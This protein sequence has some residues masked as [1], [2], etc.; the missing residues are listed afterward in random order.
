M[1]NKTVLVSAYIVM[2]IGGTLHAGIIED[3]LFSSFTSDIQKC[4]EK[5][6]APSPPSSG[7]NDKDEGWGSICSALEFEAK[8][9]TVQCPDSLADIEGYT[10]LNSYTKKKKKKFTFLS[11]LCERLFEKDE[12]GNAKTEAEIVKEKESSI[13]ASAE[14][15]T[16]DNN[17]NNPK[18]SNGMTKDEFYKGNNRALNVKK[19]RDEHKN[20]LAGLYLNSSNPDNQDGLRYLMDL[21][22]RI[23]GIQNV[24][25]VEPNDV[26]APADLGDYEKDVA[27]LRESLTT[28][29]EHSSS[30][31]LSNTLSSK[32][33]TYDNADSS[34]K[35]KAYE[36]MNKHLLDVNKVIDETSYSKK[37]IYKTLLTTKEDLAIP[38]A[39]ILD[40]YRDELK[41]KYAWKIKKQQMKDA[42]IDMLLF[43]QAK[44]LKDIAYLTAKKVVVMKE[45]FNVQQAQDEIDALVEE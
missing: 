4:Y 1:K 5:L 2:S 28:D 43:T 24:G 38:T 12:N 29:L 21:A 7:G 18:L 30:K 22:K 13:L 45:T 26:N 3:E 31:D 33:G 41:P 25:N 34:K 16:I 20:T 11:K 27:A 10:K 39:Q 42:Y 14:S 44:I 15:L 9:N 37:G 40:M 19:L 32:I 23:P 35:N 6:D 17:P 36:D 8:I